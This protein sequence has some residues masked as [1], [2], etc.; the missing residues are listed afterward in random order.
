M[1]H[2]SP[3]GAQGRKS[4]QAENWDDENDATLKSL[5]GYIIGSNRRLIP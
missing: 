4:R 1:K 5:A 3:S 2:Q